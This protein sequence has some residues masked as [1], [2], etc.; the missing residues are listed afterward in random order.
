MAKA[1]E[2]TAKNTKQIAQNTEF[3][4]EQTQVIVE[5]LENIE[6]YARLTF[7]SQIAAVIIFILVIYWS[8]R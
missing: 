5:R 8:R 3:I 2:K 1:E 7:E 6:T 4:A